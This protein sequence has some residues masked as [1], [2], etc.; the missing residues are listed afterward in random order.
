MNEELIARWNEKI[1]PEDEV[2]HIGDFAMT[3]DNEKVADILDRLNGTKYLIVGNHEGPALNNRKK[4]KWVKEY[5]ELKVKDSD[6]KNGVQRIV[7]F[8][9]AMRVWRGDYRGTWHLYG[10]S[11]GNLPD[12]EDQLSIDIG[13]DC[14]NYYPLSYDEVKAIMKTKQWKPPF[15][16]R[17]L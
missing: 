13:V 8:H 9:Y 14:H 11:H 6:C 17:E 15:E 10:H 7:L 5:H 3:K 1:R 12:N 16:N 2:Y 4:F